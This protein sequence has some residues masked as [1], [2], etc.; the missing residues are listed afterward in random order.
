MRPNSFQHQIF[1][2]TT[3]GWSDLEIE[4]DVIFKFTIYFLP[5][6]N[7]IKKSPIKGNVGPV[8]FLFC[9]AQIGYSFLHVLQRPVSNLQFPNF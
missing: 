4:M 9:K 6:E 3:I 8:I 5:D 7:A 1:F 2:I